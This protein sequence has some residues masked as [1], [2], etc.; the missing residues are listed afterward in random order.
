MKIL[1]IDDDESITKMMSRYF[2][3]KKVDC[4][5]ETDCRRGLQLILEQ[6]FDVI[7]LDLNM[8]HF[9]GF[10]VL[11]E[12]IKSEKI[13]E[14]KIIL[15]TASNIP[16]EIIMNFIAKGVHSCVGKPVTMETLLSLV[17]T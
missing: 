4:T 10:D 13:K 15:F 2:E 14:L 11:N 9:S 3:Y 6:K 16:R 17:Q 7:L 8:P 5:I 1:L 12:L